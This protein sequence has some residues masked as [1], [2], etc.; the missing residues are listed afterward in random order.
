MP[1]T[2]ASLKEYVQH[3]AYEVM[4][5]SCPRYQWQTTS[6]NAGISD[7]YKSIDWSPMN[8]ELL[9]HFYHTAPLS[10]QCNQSNGQ[11]YE[12]RRCSQLDVT[13][14]NQSNGQRCEVRR[15][16]QLDVT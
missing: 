3:C 11:R 9:K 6:A 2:G 15:C 5:I 12:V 4:L 10:M 14:C 16:S 1:Q 13:Q 8:V 7:N